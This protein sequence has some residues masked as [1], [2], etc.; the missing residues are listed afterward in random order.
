[1]FFSLRPSFR[2]QSAPRV[3]DVLDAAE[4]LDVVDDRRGREGAGDRGEGRLDARLAALAFDR[5]DQAGLLAADVRAGAAMDGD[6][7]GEAGAQDVLAEEPLRVRLFDGA[8]QD[9]SAV[10]ELAA[11]V[12]VRRLAPD[13]VRGEDHPLDELVRIVLH[14]EPV[15][16]GPRLGLVRVAEEVDRLALRVLGKEAP[17]DA[18]REAR[19]AA[20]ADVGLLDLFGDLLGR[21]A[22]AEHPAQPRVAAVG[23]IGVDRLGVGRADAAAE[24]L[25]HVRTPGR[26]GRGADRAS[27]RPWARSTCR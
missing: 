6:V 26:A 1:M 19:A 2:N 14:Q 15:L 22:A 10:V 24:D 16:E 11:D 17:L 8:I 9:A 25:F 27:P 18:G 13:R 3:D 5:L 21:H 4:R 12:D 23:E 7:E 20:A